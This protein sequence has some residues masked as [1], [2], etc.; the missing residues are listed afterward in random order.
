MSME[1]WVFGELVAFALVV[2]RVG[3][4][5]AHTAVIENQLST[6]SAYE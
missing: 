4:H 1:T 6:F 3:V 5:D 2:M